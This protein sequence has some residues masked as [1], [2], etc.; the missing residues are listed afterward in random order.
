MANAEFLDNTIWLYRDSYDTLECTLRS[1]RIVFI[2]RTL[3][4]SRGKE[5]EFFLFVPDECSRIREHI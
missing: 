2:I 4:E 1:V 5:E 3:H